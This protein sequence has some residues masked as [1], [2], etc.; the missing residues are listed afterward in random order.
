MPHLPL[1]SIPQPAWIAIGVV[2]II[3]GF[4][5]CYKGWIATVLG[6]VH[7]WSG[8]LPFTIVSPWFIHLPPSER[9]L[10]KIKEGLL[11]HA[12]I[13]P[14]FFLTAIPLIVAGLDFT[15]LPGTQG[16]NFVLNAGDSSKPPAVTYSPPMNYQFPLAI[17]ASKS[18]AK[19]FNVQIG[20]DPNKRL[21][22]KDRQSQY[23]QF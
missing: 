10:I 1:N 13:G 6:R 16:L 22:P 17:R 19:L 15:G 11:C 9:S 7:Y 14:L 20:E 12:L 3:L 18:I 23:Q 4:S 5:F 21:L 8:F 2:L